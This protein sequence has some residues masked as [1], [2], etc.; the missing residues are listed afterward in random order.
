MLLVTNSPELHVVA[1]I[2]R[3]LAGRQHAVS[4]R[5]M[6]IYTYHAVPMPSPCH[7]PATALRGRFQNGILVAWQGNRMGTAWYV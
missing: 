5:P 3:T 1:G 6:L 7:D 4:G 2:N